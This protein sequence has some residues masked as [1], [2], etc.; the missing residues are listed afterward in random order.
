MVY[1]SDS[2]LRILD[3]GY[4]ITLRIQDPGLRC[5]SRAPPSAAEQHAPML[6]LSLMWFCS[7]FV[8]RKL[9]CAQP[10]INMIS[11]NSPKQ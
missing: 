2:G 11:S 7:L 10:K 4:W 3:S 6:Q 8:A 9:G 5:C 1:I